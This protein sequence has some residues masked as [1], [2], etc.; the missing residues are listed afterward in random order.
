M[1]KPAANNERIMNKN[2]LAPPDS[3]DR[4]WAGFVKTHGITDEHAYLEKAFLPKSAISSLQLGIS[5]RCNYDC[6]FCFNHFSRKI[7]YYSDTTMPVDTVVNYFKDNNPINN[8]LFAVSGE[9]LLHP[10]FFKI[11]EGISQFSKQINISTNGGLLIPKTT[12]RLREFPIG[13]VTLSTEAGDREGYELFRKNGRFETFLTHA[14]HLI[15]TFEQQVWVTS[16]LFSEN[17]HSLLGLPKLLNSLGYRNG[18]NLQNA[19]VHPF[20]AKR[21]IRALT[22]K[23]RY[24]FL[25]PFLE[26]C[27]RF[28]ITPVWSTN[29]ISPATA[30]KIKTVSGGLYCNDPDAYKRP[31]DLPFHSFLIDPEGNYNYCC[32]ME[33]T[34]ADGFELS[35][36]DAFNKETIRKMRIMNIF[37]A[38]PQVCRKYCHKIPHNPLEVSLEN[39]S[40]Y[41]SLFRR[42][43]LSNLGLLPS[44]PEV[45]TIPESKKVILWPYGGMARQVIADK[46]FGATIVG[47]TDKNPELEKTLPKAIPFYPPDRLPAA[48]PDAIL[49]ASGVFWEEILESVDE[50]FPDGTIDVYLMTPAKKLYRRSLE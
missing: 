1:V 30:E 12:D 33:P 22:E 7:D 27:N 20:H 9:P 21:G 8:V 46:L 13:L 5:T 3:P 34:Q 24:D 6:P 47:I 45:K 32:G 28:G 49:I 29:F 26:E 4:S 15:A 19:V 14:Q 40:E 48:R 37:G 11:L 17:R 10:H 2:I 25:L 16:V 23:E 42:R 43:K 36:E 41:I 50:L 18:I 38:F 39:L 35:L 31:C 44:W